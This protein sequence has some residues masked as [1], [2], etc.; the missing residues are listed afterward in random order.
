[1]E[2]PYTL[3]VYYNGGDKLWHIHILAKIIYADNIDA[4]MERFKYRY[5]IDRIDE[6]DYFFTYKER[7]ID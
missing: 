5:A 2:T 1:M 3:K 6:I 7:V 4:L